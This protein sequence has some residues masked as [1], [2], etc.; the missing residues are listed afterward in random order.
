[1]A[2]KLASTKTQGWFLVTLF[3][4]LKE[5]SRL[6]SKYLINAYINHAHINWNLELENYWFCRSMAIS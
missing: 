1:M 4:A 5:C 2:V 3:L 6:G